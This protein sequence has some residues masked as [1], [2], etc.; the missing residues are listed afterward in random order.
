MNLKVIGLKKDKLNIVYGMRVELSVELNG[1]ITRKDLLVYLPEPNEEELIPFENL[2]ESKVLEWFHQHSE[3]DLEAI[4]TELVS[5]LEKLPV[6]K[7]N[8]PWE[9]Q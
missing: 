7:R 2:T 1:R 6:R 3:H 5:Q 4:E 9:N 8:L